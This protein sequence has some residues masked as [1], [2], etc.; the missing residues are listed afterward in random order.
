LGILPLVCPR[1]ITLKLPV[2]A[3]L[4]PKS[5]VEDGSF[6]QELTNKV[7]VESYGKRSFDISQQ[8]KTSTDNWLMWA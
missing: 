2:K 3:V 7:G 1:A 8:V 4:S 5:L 6:I